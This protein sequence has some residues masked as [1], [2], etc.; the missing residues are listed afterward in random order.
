[1]TT[2]IPN[3]T[4]CAKFDCVG[5]KNRYEELKSMILDLKIM[6]P[7]SATDDA[8]LGMLERE[9]LALQMCIIECCDKGTP[10]K[11]INKPK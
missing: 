6:S 8:K 3:C 4:D 5:A 9:A 10:P 7:L 2:N 1:M 11:P